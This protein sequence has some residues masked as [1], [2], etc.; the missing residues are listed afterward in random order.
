MNGPTAKKRSWC[1]PRTGIVAAI[2]TFFVLGS[3]AGAYAYWN[4]QAT[5]ASTA[6]AGSISVALTGFDQLQ[7]TFVN[8][9]RLRTGSITVTS[10]T[11]STRALPVTINLGI[12]AGGSTV[13]ASNLDVTLW[14]PVAAGSCT[15][16][17]GVSGTVKTGTW[18]SFPALS[19]TLVAS[20]PTTWCIR[21]SNAERSAIASTGGSLS[22]QPTVAVTLA[23]GTWTANAN[24]STTQNTQYIFTAAVPDASSWFSIKT[25]AGQCLAVSGSGGAGSSLVPTTCSTVSTQAFAFT[26]AGANNYLTAMPRSAPSLRL[27]T[28]GATTSGSPVTLQSASGAA[29]QGWQLQ[30]V[31]AGVYQMVNNNSGLCVRPSAASPNSTV[32]VF[33]NGTAAQ[34]FTLTALNFNI[35]LTCTNY[36]NTGAK[37]KVTYSWSASS[38]G[39]YTVQA[40]KDT[41]A[42]VDWKTIGFS[43][44]PTTSINIEGLL[45]DPEPI[46]TWTKDT[47]F[48]VRIVDASGNVVALS[49]IYVRISQGLECG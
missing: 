17:A 41:S 12:V 13:L 42:G 16:T 3:S 49:K 43:T 44:A 8:D 46:T 33:C 24:A 2:V 11:T 29:S 35:A 25:A 20:Q 32:Q 9:A 26:S 5:L 40:D 6:K 18:S 36:D 4:A 10:A 38:A 34:Q 19:T 22:I 14:G 7:N 39:S 28:S 30:R 15:N 37:G 1:F 48:D 23:A 31:S 27:G 45:P 47:T 21:T